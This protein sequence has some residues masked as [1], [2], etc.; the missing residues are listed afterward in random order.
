MRKT[1]I[2]IAFLLFF[3]SNVTVYGKTGESLDLSRCIDGDTFEAIKDKE[4][5][6]I[7]LLAV[8]TPELNTDEAYSE[9]AKIYACD[10]LKNNKITFEYDANSDELDKYGRH[11][12]WVYVGDDLLQEKLVRNGLANVAYLYDD[13]M[14]TDIL[15]EAELLAIED[16]LNIH[17]QKDNQSW[18]LIVT[19]GI[20]VLTIFIVKTIFIRA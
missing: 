18:F 9:E 1:Y 4:K 6:K 2:F 17:N 15:E 13:Y 11:L 19:I 7:R 3:V 10:L 5:I 8:D 14:Y 12:M 20:V 16:D